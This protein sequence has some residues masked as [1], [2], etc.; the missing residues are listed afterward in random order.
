MT[1]E[2]LASVWPELS[3]IPR[4]TAERLQTDARYAVYLD[5]QEASITTF[6]KDEAIAIPASVDFS[7]IS[8][9]STEIRQKLER[10]RSSTLAQASRIDGMTPAA[11]MLLLA[12]VKKLAK[13]AA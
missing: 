1:V 12:H 11:L 6:K 3:A 7:A 4:A 5:R 10:H 8:G 13:A 9:L 2:A